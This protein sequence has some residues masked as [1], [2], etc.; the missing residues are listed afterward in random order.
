MSVLRLIIFQ[1]CINDNKLIHIPTFPEYMYR[2]SFTFLTLGTENW[3]IVSYRSWCP[4]R[5]IAQ[6][7]KFIADSMG[8]R[9][10]DAVLLDLEAT[11]QES[12]THTPLICFLSMGSDP[13]SQIE[14]LAKKH[15]LEC[16]A[17]SMGQGQE[18]HARRLVGQFMQ[19][20]SPYF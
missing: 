4:D 7:R 11:L 5:T 2:I 13:T 16:R 10:A 6:A 17:I 15:N 19:N 9:Y 12:T 14:S 1:S 8:A 3:V 18:V 20:V